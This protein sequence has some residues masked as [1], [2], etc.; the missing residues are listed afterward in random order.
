MATALWNAAKRRRRSS[1][2]PSSRVSNGAD[3]QSKGVL[4]KFAINLESYESDLAYLDEAGVK[5]KMPRALLT[6]VDDPGQVTE[7]AAS[8]RSGT[9]LWDWILLVVLG[10]ALFEPW[11]ANKIS[12]RHY[13][14]ARRLPVLSGAEGGRSPHPSAERPAAEE[15]RS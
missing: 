8:A 4:G 13:G 2:T 11:L 3:S 12:A 9:R 6:F 10:I 7:A 1:A 14:K 5:E 15:V